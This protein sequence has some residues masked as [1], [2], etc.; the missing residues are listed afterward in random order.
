[1]NGSYFDDEMICIGG[2]MYS[3]A[4][5]WH[6]AGN[7]GQQDPGGAAPGTGPH[8]DLVFNEEYWGIVDIDR[9]PRPAYY[10][11]KELFGGF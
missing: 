10:A 3:W 11:L 6:K 1:V 2:T 8:P 5:E 7:P 9:N 4:D